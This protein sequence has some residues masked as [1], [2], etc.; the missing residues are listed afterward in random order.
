MHRRGIFFSTLTALVLGALPALAASFTFPAASVR[1]A[2]PQFWNAKPTDTGMV[3]FDRAN[4]TAVVLTAVD[5]GSIDQA[6]RAVGR[7]LA[8]MID[9]IKVTKEE[10]LT[11]NGMPAALVEGDGTKSGV[12]I[13]WAVVFV[14]TPSPRNDLMVIAIAEDAK[15]AAHRGEIRGIFTSIAPM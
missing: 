5:E 11:I 15:L 3:T 1:F 4:D 7:R 12:N 10:R 2:T 14:K 6:G 13:D 9:D 8:G